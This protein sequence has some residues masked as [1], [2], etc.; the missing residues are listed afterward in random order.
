LG[1]DEY[2]TKISGVW[3]QR[4]TNIIIDSKVDSEE[5]LINRLGYVSPVIFKEAEVSGA[6]NWV[7]APWQFNFESLNGAFSSVLENGMITEVDDNGARLLGFLSLDGIR[8]SLNLEFDNVFSKGLG[9][10]IMSSSANINNGIIKNEDYYLDG[11]AGKISGGGLVDL[12][13]LNV[14]YHFSYSPA[15]TSS[16]PVLAAFTINPLTGAAVLML[17]KLLEPVVDT[18]V[19][20]DFSVKGSLLDPIVKIESREKGKVK[21]QNSA[22]LEA[23][24]DKQLSQGTT[25]EQ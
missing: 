13:N 16:L 9:F 24:E 7:G 23:M 19:R 2:F 18:I 3:D 21:L 4:R 14:N 25:D 6:L 5:S 17:T 10:D 1:G 8:R 22:V 15:V 20:V 12:P 11:S